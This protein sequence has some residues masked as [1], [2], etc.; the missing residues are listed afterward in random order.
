MKATHSTTCDTRTLA[1]AMV[2][3]VFHSES[4]A[5]HQNTQKATGM[6]ISSASGEKS[7]NKMAMPTMSSTALTRSNRWEFSNAV[8]ISAA[9]G[10]R[11]LAPGCG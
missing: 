9:S 5:S 2:L 10:K 4:G 3:G 11:L 1:P 7:P 6:L 8:S